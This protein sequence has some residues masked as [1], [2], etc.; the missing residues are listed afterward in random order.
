MKYLKYIIF[1]CFTL[2]L[3]TELSSHILSLPSC[4]VLSIMKNEIFSQSC[5]HDNKILVVMARLLVFEKFL[6]LPSIT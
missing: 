1:D 4:L 2:W 3:Q 5:S 6:L